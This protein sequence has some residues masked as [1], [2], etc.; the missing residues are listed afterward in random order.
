M[1]SHLRGM[2]LFKIVVRQGHHKLPKILG[3]HVIEFV[4]S[5]TPESRLMKQVHVF[6][7]ASDVPVIGRW[8]VSVLANQAREANGEG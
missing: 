1:I 3:E 7:T 8:L 4:Y 2:M 5:K 6:H